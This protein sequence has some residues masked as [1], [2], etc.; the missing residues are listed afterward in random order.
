M[1]T[2]PGIS[3]GSVLV[4][5]AGLAA[6][7]AA[8]AEKEDIAT[9][10]RA[11]LQ[12]SQRVLEGLTTEN[13]SMVAKNS[14]AMSLLSQDQMW[15]VLQTPEYFQRSAEFRRAVDSLTEAAKKEN[16]DGATLAYVDVTL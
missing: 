16:L 14:Q 11:K 6:F 9:F 12:H 8:A 5:A 13:L 1:K 15:R 3:V 7:P 10:M 2:I 4:L